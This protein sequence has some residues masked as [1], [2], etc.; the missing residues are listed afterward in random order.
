M[1]NQRTKVDVRSK[2]NMIMV[3]CALVERTRWR[4]VVGSSG[5]GHEKVETHRTY[6][7]RTW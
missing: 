4:T 7:H 1:I 2:G 3:I 5:C 6:W